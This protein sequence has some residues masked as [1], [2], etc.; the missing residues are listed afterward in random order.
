M[1]TTDNKIYVFLFSL[2]LSL[3]TGALILKIPS[4][5]E[6]VASKGNI[7]LLTYGITVVLFCIVYFFGCLLVS[8]TSVSGHRQN[9]ASAFVVSLFLMAADF[10]FCFLCSKWK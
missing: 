2:F 9:P 4:L 1:K 7:N 6:V 3:G 10:V 8:R 5:S